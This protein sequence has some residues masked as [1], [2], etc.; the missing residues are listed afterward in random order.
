MWIHRLGTETPESV[1]LI[2]MVVA[3]HELLGGGTNCLGLEELDH[4]GIP[5]VLVVH[6]H[7]SNGAVKG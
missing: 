4:T 3:G 1:A 7:R 2:G 5:T 6:D